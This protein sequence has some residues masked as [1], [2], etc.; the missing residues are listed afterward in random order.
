MEGHRTTRTTVRR[1]YRHN[2]HWY[3]RVA[4][5]LYVFFGKTGVLNFDLRGN[6]LWQADVGDRTDGWGSGTSPILF[7]N[8]VI[9]DASVESRSLVAINKED[10]K[11]AWRVA[12]MDSS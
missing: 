8:R 2:G 5:Y 12:E 10:G 7:K 3:F 4:E 6:Q 9:V 1:V 11:E